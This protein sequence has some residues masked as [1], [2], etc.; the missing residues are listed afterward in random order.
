MESSY[1]RSELLEA[2]RKIDFIW[3]KDLLVKDF[4]KKLFRALWARHF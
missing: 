2:V 1:P 4:S 3:Q